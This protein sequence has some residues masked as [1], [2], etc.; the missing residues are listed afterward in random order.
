MLLSLSC[1]VAQFLPNQ[2]VVCHLGVQAQHELHVALAQQ[3]QV[4]DL[5]DALGKDGCVPEEH[6]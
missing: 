1:V 3:T 2:C 6:S 5:F 4:G